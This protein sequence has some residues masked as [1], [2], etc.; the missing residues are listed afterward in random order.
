MG[1][2]IVIMDVVNPLFFFFF[3]FFSFLK[4]RRDRTKKS[5]NFV[6]LF[7]LVCLFIFGGNVMF[8]KKKQSTVE[9]EESKQKKL[10]EINIEVIPKIKTSTVNNVMMNQDNMDSNFVQK[11]VERSISRYMGVGM[12]V[13]RLCS[14]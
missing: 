1:I 13:D 14:L 3:S 5:N 12:G 4:R 9:V 11:S 2:V 10:K 7:G 8:E 6:W